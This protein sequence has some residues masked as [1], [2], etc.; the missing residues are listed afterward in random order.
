MEELLNSL[1]EPMQINETALVVAV[2]F[3]ILVPILNSMIFQPLMAILDDRK[4]QITEGEEASLHSQKTVEECEAKYKEDLF[5][6]RK[7]AQ[8]DAQKLLKDSEMAREKIISASKEKAMAYVQA[9][10]TELDQ[11]VESAKE[12]LK[13]DTDDL[14]KQ[15]VSAVLSRS[16]AA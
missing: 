7:Q 1:P 2:L 14:A 16:S 15:I 10:A 12:A 3:L 13:S 5:Q 4:K 9:T 6:A 11:Q 8:L